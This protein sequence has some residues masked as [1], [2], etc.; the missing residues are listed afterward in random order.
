MNKLDEAVKIIHDNNK[1][2]G[3]IAST[4]E[5]LSILKDKK[6]D[7]VTYSVDS[8]M[9]QNAYKKIINKFEQ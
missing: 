2:V 3:S 8:G 4:P 6:L 5:M 1:K 9:V 7:Y